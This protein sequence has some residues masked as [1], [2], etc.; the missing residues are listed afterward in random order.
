MAE[1]GRLVPNF[2]S[3]HNVKS[4]LAAPR[5]ETP[6]QTIVFSPRETDAVELK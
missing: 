3:P 2:L 5:N 6:L 4:P 1:R